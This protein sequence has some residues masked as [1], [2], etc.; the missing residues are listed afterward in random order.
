M[1][2]K[3]LTAALV[4]VSCVL[5]APGAHSETLFADEFDGEDL[6]PH[7]EVLNADPDSFIV[8][9]GTLLAIATGGAALSDGSV[10]NVFRLKESLPKGDWVATMQFRMPYQ[11]GRETAFFGLYDDKDTYFAASLG[12]WSYYEGTRGARL[13]LGAGKSV[14]GKAISFS[15]VIWGGAGGEAFDLDSVPNP[16]VL[17][18]EK[19]GR[20]YIPSVR[21]AQGAEETW[22]TFQ[23]VSLLRPSGGLAFGLYQAETVNGETPI[24]VDWIRIETA[25]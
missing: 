17:R 8:E 20:T 13:F 4:V 19:M 1:Q 18:I 23:S 7:W 16:F 15:N 6:A 12:A 9:D 21:V 24:M 22:H 14:K 2:R 10:A 5:F 11:T 25:P 3:S